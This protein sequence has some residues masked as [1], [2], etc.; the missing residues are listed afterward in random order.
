[1]LNVP[2]TVKALFQRD[3]VRKNFRVHFP[4]GELPDITNE[5]IVQES[6][7]FTE[8]LCSQDVLKFGLTEASVIEFE[9]V[10]IGNMYGMTIEC[11]IEIDLSS[12]SAAQLNDIASGTWDGVYTAAGD[13][14]IGYAYFRVPYG[15]FRVESCPR[16][17]QAMTHRK[18]QALTKNSFENN[19]QVING[20]YSVKN[21]KLNPFLW[22]EAKETDKSELT[23]IDSNN[24]GETSRNGPI[25]VPIYSGSSRIEYLYGVRF[26]SFTGVFGQ[27][28]RII[29]VFG[30]GQTYPRGNYLLIVDYETHEFDAYG[31][32]LIDAAMASLPNRDFTSSG[33]D[34]KNNKDVVSAELGG[35]QPSYSICIQWVSGSD[36]INQRSKPIFIK[37]NEKYILDLNNFSNF[38]FIRAAPSGYTVSEVY[39][40]VNIPIRWYKRAG[41][42]VDNT[43]AK[44]QYSVTSGGTSTMYYQD[45]TGWADA[46]PFGDERDP[47]VTRNGNVKV[48]LGEL[49]NQANLLLNIAST[50]EFNKSSTL[51]M[52]YTYANAVSSIAFLNGLLELMAKFGRINRFGAFDKLQLSNQDPVSVPLDQYSDFWWDEYDVLPVGTINY[53]FENAESGSDE[54]IASYHFGNG[55]SIYDMTDNEILKNIANATTNDVEDMLDTTFI[56]NIA[57]IAFTP[58]DLTMK[59]LPYMEAGDYL[60]VVAE[61]GTI[62]YSFNMR[63]EISGIQ[64][65]TASIESTSGDIIESGESE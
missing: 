48:F 47:V 21:I 5:N 44:W 29:G 32:S 49:T 17:H 23:E 27:N 40:Y 53:T 33:R 28:G 14:D 2:A 6:V 25:I 50:L 46:A 13:S 35:L 58:I 8:S 39:L 22:L 64:V 15:V 16:D 24:Y 61:D 38:D 3:G 62:A 19:E 45:I 9:T 36:T 4:N 26:A 18:V 59:G 60:A 34:A 41:S 42:S 52:Y 11:G 57:P 55:E 31:N 12:L 10:G 30:E 7:K 54:N 63:Q 43:T 1:M 65:L 37:P 51:G 20:Q 56:P